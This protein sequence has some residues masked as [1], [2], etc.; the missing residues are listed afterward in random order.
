M[1]DGLLAACGLCTNTGTHALVSLS[2]RLCVVQCSAVWCGV[3]YWR[4]NQTEVS[5]GSSL[6]LLFTTTPTW[7]S[8]SLDLRCMLHVQLPVLAL[9]HCTHSHAAHG[10]Q[11]QPP[12][13][14][15]VHISSIYMTVQQLLGAPSASSSVR[16]MCTWLGSAWCV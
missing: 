9:Q 14:R 8:M 7:D 2:G 3:V 13:R 12:S 6:P 11:C 4:A 10:R 5:H 16:S 15:G 1:S